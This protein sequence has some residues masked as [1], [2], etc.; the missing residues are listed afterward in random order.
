MK[1][2]ACSLNKMVDVTFW[3]FIDRSQLLHLVN[4]W[5]IYQ[6]GDLAAFA[7]DQCLTN[8]RNEVILSWLVGTNVMKSWC[9]HWICDK[10][11]DHSRLME[12][13]SWVNGLLVSFRHNGDLSLKPYLH[14]DYLS[15]TAAL[16]KKCPWM[17]DYCSNLEASTQIIIFF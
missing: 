11:C 8:I 9:W 13:F 5:L 14:H 6:W 3:R 17:A 4:A 16:C 7:F 15:C 2:N 1:R 10:I 12:R